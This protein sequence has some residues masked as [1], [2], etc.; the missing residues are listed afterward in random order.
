MNSYVT[1]VT[2]EYDFRTAITKKLYFGKPIA[3]DFE[4]TGVESITGLG[5]IVFTSHG[6]FYCESFED[7]NY[8]SRNIYMKVTEY[9]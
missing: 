8:Y 2:Q 4:I 1:H 3:E 7:D 9:I 6:D 5:S